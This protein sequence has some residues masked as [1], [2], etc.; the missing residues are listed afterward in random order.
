M[1]SIYNLISLIKGNQEFIEDFADE[2]VPGAMGGYFFT[3]EKSKIS[4]L[5]KL[6]NFQK[7]LKQSMKFL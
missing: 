3:L 7:M 1:N 5:F 4:R 2:G 6:E